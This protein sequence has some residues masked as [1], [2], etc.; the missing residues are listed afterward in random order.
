MMR[1]QGARRGMILRRD[2][3]DPE[4]AEAALADV[5]EEPDDDE[6]PIPPPEA[7]PTPVVAPPPLLPFQDLPREEHVW[8]RV[9]GMTHMRVN[10]DNYTHQSGNIRAYLNCGHHDNC[11]RYVFVRTFSQPEASSSMAFGLGSCLHQVART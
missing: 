10:F 5:A 8:C 7:P 1:A 2:M 6:L 3:D 4:E 11:R 9:P